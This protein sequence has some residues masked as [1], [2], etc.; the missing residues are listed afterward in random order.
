MFMEPGFPRPEVKVRWVNLDLFLKYMANTES[1][2][3][4]FW[5][6]FPGILWFS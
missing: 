6:S 1:S 4:Y 2:K 3:P 5:M